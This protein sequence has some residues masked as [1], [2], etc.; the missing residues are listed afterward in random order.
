[1]NE[2][3]LLSSEDIKAI[4]ERP[5]KLNPRATADEYEMERYMNVANEAAKAIAGRACP[6]ETRCRYSGMTCR[7]CWLSWIDKQRTVV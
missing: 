2:Q 5:T 4:L 6:P 3:M 7:E 1:M